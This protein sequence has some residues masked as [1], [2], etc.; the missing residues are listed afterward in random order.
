MNSKTIYTFTFQ[1]SHYERFKPPDWNKQTLDNHSSASGAHNILVKI[2]NKK[3]YELLKQYIE[4]FGDELGADTK[5]R[6]YNTPL[7]SAVWIGDKV[8]TKLLLDSGIYN[9]NEKFYTYYSIVDIAY[10]RGHLNILKMFVKHSIFPREFIIKSG[11]YHV[12]YD[13]HIQSAQALTVLMTNDELNNKIVRAS[14]TSNDKS[15][16]NLIN[17]VI[18]TWNAIDIEKA[19]KFIWKKQ[20]HVKRGSLSDVMRNRISVK[21]LNKLIVLPLPPKIDCAAHEIDTFFTMYLSSTSNEIISSIILQILK[22]EKPD[23]SKVRRNTLNHIL[24]C[25]IRLPE[26]LSLQLLQAYVEHDMNISYSTED[27]IYKTIE[28]PAVCKFLIRNGAILGQNWNEK[29][30]IIDQ[31]IRGGHSLYDFFPDDYK[32]SPDDV[33]CILFKGSNY[34]EHDALSTFN[35]LEYKISEI[36]DSTYIES[37]SC[38]SE[39]I[40]TSIITFLFMNDIDIS[41][42]K[43]LCKTLN[44]AILEGSYDLI[45]KLI[46]DGVDVNLDTATGPYPIESAYAVNRYD[47]C[48]LL[49]DN[50]AD[51]NKKQKY[52]PSVT[53]LAIVDCNKI[54]YDLFIGY[55][56]KIEPDES[57]LKLI[58]TESADV[59]MID[60]TH[61]N[62]LTFLMITYGADINKQDDKGDTPLHWAMRRISGI[63]HILIKCGVDPN[64]KNDKGELPMD[65]ATSS[66]ART[67]LKK[68]MQDRC[69]TKPA[70]AK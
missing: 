33:A 34:I 1:G 66:S 18:N 55:G 61:K 42:H 63:Y 46:S 36:L 68:Y 51:P 14:F 19:F 64:I 10:A 15:R 23:F 56:G 69:L 25:T 27:L 62:L 48:K 47:I 44:S 8:S 67:V 29:E 12:V 20:D 22:S 6:G 24:N 32:F 5:Y 17:Y 38:P 21:L 65:V 30:N 9:P 45:E 3:N 13:G 50:G 43:N 4:C 54:M 35:R 16:Y 2:V 49:L 52:N 37:N 60:N 31:I 59:F 57:I 40:K 41:E 26:H 39:D 58:I 28:L 53:A 7:H 11:I 70:A